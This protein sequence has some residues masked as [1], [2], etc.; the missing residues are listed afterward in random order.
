MYINVRLK[1]GNSKTV[2]W[3]TEKEYA[4]MYGEPAVSRSSDPFFKSQ[5]DVL[6]FVKGYITIFKGDEGRNE[7]N[8]YFKLNSAYRF[9]RWWG[10]YVPSDLELPDDLPE[11]AE[12]VQLNWELVGNPT[13]EIKSD[14]AVETAIGNLFYPSDE[15]SFP[16]SVGERIEVT[17][18]VEKN[19]DIETKF[20]HSSLHIFSDSTGNIYSWLTASKSWPV[21]NEYHIRGTV[22]ENKIYKG[23]PQIVL[24]RCMERK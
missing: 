23:Q 17:V 5:K 2:R 16:Y 19:I 22:K 12:P 4:K 13:G 11:D 9:A 18:K 8:E 21:G 3:Y 15:I 10:W 1:N 6:G 20:G 7:E 24:T 14:A